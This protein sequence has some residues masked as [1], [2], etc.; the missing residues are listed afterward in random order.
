M[1]FRNTVLGEMSQAPKATKS[2]LPFIYGFTPIIALYTF[3]G[4]FENGV[5]CIYIFIPF[6]VPRPFPLKMEEF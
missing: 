5:S 1:N 6:L 2:F 4:E 3:T